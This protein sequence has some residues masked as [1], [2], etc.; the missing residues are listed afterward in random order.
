VPRE[1]QEK[2]FTKFFRGE[3]GSKDH[4]N[5]VGLGLYLTKEIIHRHGG[6]IWYEARHDG[7][8]FVFTIA[9]ETT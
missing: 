6:E 3:A 1:Q 7:S 5:G 4:R 2:L 8:D 9:K